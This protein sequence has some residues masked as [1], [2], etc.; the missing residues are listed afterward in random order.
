MNSIKVTADSTC[1][2]RTSGWRVKRLMFILKPVLMRKIDRWHS[3]SSLL[4][5]QPRRAPVN[6]SVVRGLIAHNLKLLYVQSNGGDDGPDRQ[7]AFVI[8][9]C[10]ALVGAFIRLPIEPAPTWLSSSL[11]AGGT[12]HYVLCA[13][14][15]SRWKISSRVIRTGVRWKNYTNYCQGHATFFA[16][17]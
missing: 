5:T 2:K 7:T 12:S 11:P 1:T 8:C 4:I 17:F 6:F 15:L 14:K 9:C 3:F 10:W 16:F 13:V